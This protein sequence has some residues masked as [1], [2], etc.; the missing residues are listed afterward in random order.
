MHTR[1]ASAIV[2]AIFGALVIGPLCERTQPYVR[3]NG[4]ITPAEPTRGQEVVIEYD[5]A[6][7]RRCDGEAVRHVIDGNGMDH[8]Y[9]PHRAIIPQLAKDAPVFRLTFVLPNANDKSTENE[10]TYYADMKYRCNWTQRFWPITEQTPR[11]RFRVK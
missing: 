2:G 8:E 4:R 6:V 10:W 9:V 11:I 5:V 7:W 1:I 3:T